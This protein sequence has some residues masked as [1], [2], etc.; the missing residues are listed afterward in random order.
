MADKMSI[1]K[2]T[3]LSP[4]SRHQQQN[5]NQQHAG[6]GHDDHHDS[7]DSLDSSPE[8]DHALPANANATPSAHSVTADGQQPKRKGGRKPVRVSA[9]SYARLYANPGFSP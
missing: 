9:W 1:D 8:D 5:Q 6:Q 2:N 3:N 7:D 4:T